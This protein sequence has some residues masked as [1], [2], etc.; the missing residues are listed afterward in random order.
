MNAKV[1]EEQR[2]ELALHWEEEA[3]IQALGDDDVAEL[4]RIVHRARNLLAYRAAH[5]WRAAT[6]RPQKTRTSRNVTG[7]RGYGRIE[8]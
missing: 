7:D 1:S 4:D 5:G 6:P 3:C 8:P 2:I